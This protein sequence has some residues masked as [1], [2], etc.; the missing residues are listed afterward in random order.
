MDRFIGLN[1][2]AIIVPSTHLKSNMDRFIATLS[3]I[4][5]DFFN[6]LKS[7]MDRFIGF[8]YI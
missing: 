8:A 7:N 4:T 5:T 1:I 6:D 2:F 3:L